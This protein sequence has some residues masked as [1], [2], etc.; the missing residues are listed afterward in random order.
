MFTERSWRRCWPESRFSLVASRAAVSSRGAS[1]E[2]RGAKELL[3]E[4][5]VNHASIE[6]HHVQIAVWSG[7]HIGAD[8]EVPPKQQA[9]ALGDVEL[10]GIVGNAV[11]QSWIVDADLLP[12]AGETEPKEVAALECGARGTDKEVAV[13]LR[14]ERAP[15]QEPNS[16]GCNGELPAEFRIAVMCAGQHEQPRQGLLWSVRKICR[17]PPQL[18]KVLPAQCRLD[19]FEIRDS[20]DRTDDLNPAGILARIDLFEIGRA[21]V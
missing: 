2:R 8:A 13:V 21:H 16:A 12:V 3:L 6:R 17:W 15:V 18:L 7:H 5:L 19:A 20:I 1:S 10:R 9:L 14:S 11:L 4:H